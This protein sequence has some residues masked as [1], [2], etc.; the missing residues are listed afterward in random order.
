MSSRQRL[1][2]IFKIKTVRFTVDVVTIL[3]R[4]DLLIN[5]ALISILLG[6]PA[7]VFDSFLKVDNLC[8]CLVRLRHGTDS[9]Q[10]QLKIVPVLIYFFQMQQIVK[11]CKTEYFLFIYKCLFLCKNPFNVNLEP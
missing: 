1:D 4:N 7:H 9:M 11:V 10:P 2:F 3:T 8:R 6:T 5:N